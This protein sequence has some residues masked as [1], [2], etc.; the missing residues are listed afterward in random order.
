MTNHIDSFR[1]AIGAS[2]ITPPD[3]LIDDGVLHRFPIGKRNENGWYVLHGDGIAAGTFGNWAISGSTEKWCSRSDTDMTQAERDAH[4]QRMQEAQRQRN[5]AKAQHQKEAQVVATERWNS[6]V[7]ATEHPYLTRKG[8]Q[9]FGVRVLNGNLLVPLRDTDGVI[10]S[11]QAI[12]TNGE[13]RFLG[14]GRVSG[15]YHSIGPA[16]TDK[17]AVAEGFATG[18]SIY[19]ATGVPV[20]VAFNAGN[21]EAVGRALRA[22]YPDTRLIFGADDDWKTEGNPGITKAKQAAQAVGGLLSIPNFE[23]IDRP[24][25]AT[26]MN[27]LHQLKGIEAVRACIDMAVAP[28]APTEQGEDAPEDDAEQ[29]GKGKPSQSS[30]LVTFVCANA[31]LFHDKNSDAF[32]LVEAVEETLRLTGSKFKNWLMA[33]FFKTT[34]KAARDQSVREALSVLIGLALHDCEERDVHIRVALHEGAYFIDLGQQGDSTAIRI[35]EG[36]WELVQK[37]PVRFLRPESL[38]P[39]PVPTMGSDIHR[40]WDFV[41]VPE[42]ARLL[43]LAWL[44]ECLRPDTAFPVLE[45]VGEAGTAKSTTQKYLRML[46]DPNG[47]NLRGTPKSVEDVFVGAG[48]NWITSYENV[49]HLSPALQDALCVL[50]T[51]GGYATRKFYTNNEESVIDVMRPTVLNG[52]SACVTAHDLIDRT[53]SIEPQIIQER[54]EDGDIGREFNAAYSGLVGALFTLMARGIAYLPQAELPPKDRP[55]MAAFARL[56]VAVQ[57]ALGYPKGEFMRQFHLSR[58]ESIGRTIDGSPVAAAFLEWFESPFQGKRNAEMSLKALLVEVEKHKPLNSEAWPKSPKGFGDAL[59]RAAPSL[60]YMG[61]EVRSLG[62]VGSTVK[63]SVRGVECAMFWAKQSRECRA[64]RDDAE[65][66]GTKHDMHDIHD[67]VLLK[68]SFT[69]ELSTGT[70]TGKPLPRAISGNSGLEAQDATQIDGQAD[71]QAPEKTGKTFRTEIL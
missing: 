64:S 5:E 14:G 65:K 1:A 47:S 6:A 21:L 70:T 13:K 34:G 32:A 12:D 69:S 41:N 53:I 2:G 31:E 4:R 45:I 66:I 35:A 44:C 48:A 37:P 39:L 59:R 63:W 20:V 16:P 68:T 55:R 50:A 9:P 49:S 62:K 67:M 26:D 24:E 15:L 54:R 7:P 57:M 10:H 36:S 25:K 23:G 56:G 42:D 29:E 46:I 61:V 43:V 30:Q 58:M 11:L 27:D 3:T 18:A 17:L 28:V 19:I 22:K 51:G 38:R 60:R 52:I 33:A 71:K 8:V 40:L